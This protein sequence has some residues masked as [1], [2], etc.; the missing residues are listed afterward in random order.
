MKDDTFE[1]LLGTVVVVRRNAC[2]VGTVTS[3]LRGA[4]MVR[5][6]NGDTVRAMIS[7][8]EDARIARVSI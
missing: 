3:V 8:P 5:L 1:K 7:G 4:R 2:H 6:L